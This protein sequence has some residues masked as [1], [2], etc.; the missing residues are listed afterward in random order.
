VPKAKK[1]KGIREAMAAAGRAADAKLDAISKS[2][3]KNEKDIVDIKKMVKDIQK[4]LT[5]V[6]GPAKKT[7]TAK[8]SALAK[9]TNAKK[10]SASKKKAAPKKRKKPAKK[11]K[12]VTKSSLFPY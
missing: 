5:K 3:A 12:Q 1:P 4:V 7:G 10:Q 2:T 6:A 8:K 11:R 9:K